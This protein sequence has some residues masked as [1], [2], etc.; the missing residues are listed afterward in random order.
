MH[1][2]S[3]TAAESKRGVKVGHFAADAIPGKIDEGI[4]PPSVQPRIDEEA[5]FVW[6]GSKNGEAS[7]NSRPTL[8]VP[9]PAT[10]PL[11]IRVRPG[12]ATR[13][14]EPAAAASPTG[15]SVVFWSRR[16]CSSVARPKTGWWNDLYRR[17]PTCSRSTVGRAISRGVIKLADGRLAYGSSIPSAM[18]LLR[19]RGGRSKIRGA[20]YGTR[21]NLRRGFAG[22]EACQGVVR[23]CHEVGTR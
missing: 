9:V 11:S 17:I 8:E 18:A 20:V 3:F 10:R 7:D 22:R 1:L 6:S 16:Q 2:S 15:A 12:P 5:A 14:G 4:S 23:R 19:Q 21:T 13:C